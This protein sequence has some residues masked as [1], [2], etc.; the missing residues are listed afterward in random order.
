[1]RSA[2][3]LPGSSQSIG[4]PTA[5]I[6]DVLCVYTLSRNTWQ[7]RTPTHVVHLGRFPSVPDCVVSGLASGGPLDT[8]SSTTSTYAAFL[9]R[10]AHAGGADCHL[11]KACLRGRLAQLNRKGSSRQGNP[12][13]AHSAGR[14]SAAA[15]ARPHLAIPSS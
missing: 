5:C 3:L 4:Y 10:R 7:L 11:G 1:M 9:G 8:T 14:G 15:H 6:C 12:G 13:Q 2:L